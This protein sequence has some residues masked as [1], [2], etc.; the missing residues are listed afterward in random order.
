MQPSWLQCALLIY[1]QTYHQKNQLGPKQTPF[2]LNKN[3]IAG[4]NIKRELVVLA[5]VRSQRTNEISPADIIFKSQPHIFRCEL[6]SFD[7]LHYLWL[8]SHLGIW[9]IK[10]ST[11]DLFA[12]E[13]YLFLQVMTCSCRC[14]NCSFLYSP[15]SLSSVTFR[16]AKCQSGSA[17]WL[18]PQDRIL[19]NRR[20][21][22]TTVSW[23]GLTGST[24]FP[25]DIYYQV[26]SRTILGRGRC[27]NTLKAWF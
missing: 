2:W 21:S 22:L 3:Q 24:I 26:S 10:D 25:N 11:L 19:H 15:A 16:A 14:H 4:K 9:H 20:P 18:L 7:C 5:W 27:R 12:L 13:N 1:S 6:M 17:H 8:W 23:T